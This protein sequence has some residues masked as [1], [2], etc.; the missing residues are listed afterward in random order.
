MSGDIVERLEELL[1]RYWHLAYAEGWER[2]T[3]DTVNGDAQETLEQIQRA[4]AGQQEMIVRLV[5][6]GNE[7]VALMREMGES[8]TSAQDRAS[9]A[10]LQVEALTRALERIPAFFEAEAIRLDD[11]S[12]TCPAGRLREAAQHAAGYHR[13]TATI[14]RS[15]SKEGETNG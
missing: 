1:S 9:S 14:I 15:L 8:I 4:F 13:S 10:L 2:R 12:M 11:E 7:D 5:A 6:A 3:T